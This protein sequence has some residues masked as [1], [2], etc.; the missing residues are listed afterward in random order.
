MSN[1]IIDP[2]KITSS[3]PSVK[4]DVNSTQNSLQ[5][6]E[7]RDGL[8]TM[9]DGSFRAVVGCKSINFDLMSTAEREAIEYSYQNF[10]NSLYFPVQILIRSKKV[11]IGPYLE[12]L[13]AI[14]STQDN[15]LLNVLMDDYINYID[16]LSQE[17]NIMDK[18]F[19]VVV[20]FFPDGDIEN[21]KLQT[22]NLLSR[23]FGSNNLQTVKVNRKTYDKAKDELM[24]RLNVVISGL[25][26]VGIQSRQLNTQQLGQLYYGFHNPDISTKEPLDDFAPIANLYT[27]KGTGEAPRL[28]STEGEQ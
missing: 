6:A 4:F 14:R 1:P 16:I 18:S 23:T 13:V 3:E 25:G 26:Q 2:N 27:K 12:K 10:L 28:G 8:V 19:Y 11:D 5:I 22:K 9:K 7:L 24:N 17:A 21:A 20:P 15:M